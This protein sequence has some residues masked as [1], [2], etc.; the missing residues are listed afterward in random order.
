MNDEK[1]PIVPVA[2][3]YGPFILCPECEFTQNSEF[4]DWVKVYLKDNSSVI[5]CSSKDCECCIN[6]YAC[7]NTVGIIDKMFDNLTDG[8]TDEDFWDV[9]GD[10]GDKFNFDVLLN[11]SSEITKLVKLFIKKYHDS[12]RDVFHIYDYTLIC[13]ECHA[14]ND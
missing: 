7:G 6:P 11:N 13:D 8:L 10:D 12:D 5:N 4:I 9:L 14:Q 3:K 2:I 1:E